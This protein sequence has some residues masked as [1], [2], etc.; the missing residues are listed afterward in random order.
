MKTRILNIIIIVFFLNSC[1][2]ISHQKF[3]A[4]KW[5]NANLN[6]EENWDLR[7]Q[8]MNDLR[9]N[10]DLE[11][12]NKTQIIKSLGNPDS[13]TKNEYNYNLGMTGTG[14][15]TGNLTIVFKENNKV[16]KINVRQG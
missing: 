12:M 14:I 10:F 6:L 1:G 2:Q 5:Q 8:M 4:N 9:N 11:E 3:D 13:E 7:W 15:N 16:K